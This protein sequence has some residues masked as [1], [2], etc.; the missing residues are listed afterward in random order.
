MSLAASLILLCCWGW[1]GPARAEPSLLVRTAAAMYTPPAPRPLAQVAAAAPASAAPARPSR[2][3]PPLYWSAGL[4]LVAGGTAW[5]SARQADR[6]YQRYLHSAGLVRQREQLRRS[7]HH[8]RIAGA[9]FGFMEAGIVL[10]TY[11]VFF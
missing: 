11:L 7:R 10:S 9:A 1:A 6:A 4:T 8:D 5:W 2:L 3:R